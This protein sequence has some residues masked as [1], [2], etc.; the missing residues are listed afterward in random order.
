MI[1]G[2]LK[3]LATKIAKS[4]ATKKFGKKTVDTVLKVAKPKQTAKSFIKNKVG[5][6]NIL[7]KKNLI[8]DYGVEFKAGEYKGFKKDIKVFNKEI[9]KQRKKTAKLTG[10]SLEQVNKLVDSG[11]DRYEHLKYRSD[12]LPNVTTKNNKEKYLKVGSSTYDEKNRAIHSSYLKG[13]ENQGIDKIDPELYEHLFNM[14]DDE[15]MKIR[16]EQEDTDA[17]FL[18]SSVSVQQKAN[19]IRLMNGLDEVAINEFDIIDY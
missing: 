4:Y 5:L 12:N 2:F 3:G 16:Y 9:L 8:N 13:L 1:L 17:G 10:Q 7:S 15:F 11:D 19:M 14:S 6:D 18:Y